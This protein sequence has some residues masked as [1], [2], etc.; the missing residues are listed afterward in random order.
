[1]VELGI[2]GFALFIATI[3]SSLRYLRAPADPGQES[4]EGAVADEPRAFARALGIGMCGLCI[5]GFFLSELYSNVFWTFVTL[6]CAV[7][8]VRR[9]P[10]G[11]RSVTP[12]IAGAVGERAG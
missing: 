2:P 12:Y 11:A 1:L 4:L 9:I 6:S 10:K 8:I 3:F 5:S 7:G